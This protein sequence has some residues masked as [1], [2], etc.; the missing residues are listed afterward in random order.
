MSG[1]G[2]FLAVFIAA[3]VFGGMLGCCVLTIAHTILA[4]IQTSRRQLVFLLAALGVVMALLV[5]LD[6]LMMM[7][8]ALAIAVPFAVLVLPLCFPQYIG[9]Q[10]GMWR[11]VQCYLVIYIA[12]IIVSILFYDAMMPWIFWHTPL[13]NSL[14][15]VCLILGYTGLAMIVY[16]MLDRWKGVEGEKSPG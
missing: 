12:G 6:T 5:Q 13:S 11:I 2:G 4:R 3:T 16:R 10:P 8:V 9:G 14:I 1:T 15:Y 7:Y